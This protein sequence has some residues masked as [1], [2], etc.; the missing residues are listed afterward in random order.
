[1]S[2][3]VERVLAVVLTACLVAAGSGFVLE[4]AKLAGGGNGRAAA[5]ARTSAPPP[6]A[7]ANESAAEPPPPE[8]SPSE[9]DRGLQPEPETTCAFDTPAGLAPID[10]AGADPREQIAAIAKRDELLRGHRFRHD[11]DPVFQDGDAL[12]EDLTNQLLRAYTR[13]E[14]DRD[15]RILAALGAVPNDVNLRHVA[16]EGLGGDVLGYYVPKTKKLLVKR[17]GDGSTLGPGEKF[18]LSHE[19]EHALADQALHLPKT[20]GARPSEAD[21]IAARQALIEGDATITMLRYAT[22][23]LTDEERL[24]LATDPALT[25][26]SL[27]GAPYF[28]R[29]TF[30]F[31]YDAGAKFVCA[32]FELGGWDAVDDAYDRP[33]TTTAQILFPER[34]RDREHAADPRNPGR[35]SRAWRRFP[36]DSVGAADLLWLL[37]APGGHTERALDDP[38]GRVAA[39]A[40]GEAHLYTKGPQTAVALDLVALPGSTGLCESIDAWYRV[41]IPVDRLF[42]RRERERFALAGKS[43]A[44]VL[45]CEGRDIRLGIAPTLPVARKLAL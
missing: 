13:A 32:L 28:V 45:H 21:A 11:V 20:S 9:A 6:G 40:G 8:P 44:A 27:A 29:K 26:S 34:Y 43:Q 14:A 33:P 15:K 35:P 5:P 25:G 42:K 23:A 31:P 7:T 10:D 18:I 36:A 3:R 39:W 2:F 30:E 41:S 17:L 16:A 37:Q 1:M 12:A 22:T 4:V 24:S 19:L 38:L